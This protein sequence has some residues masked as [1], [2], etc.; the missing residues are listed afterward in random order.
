MLT[1]TKNPNG[2]GKMMR[3]VKCL[4]VVVV[5][6]P[7]L[8]LAASG[9]G[10]MDALGVGTP[11]MAASA[12]NPGSQFITVPL[13]LTNSQGLA[14]ADIP[15]RF[16]DPG[17]GVELREVK[18]NSRIDYFDVK[19][20]NIDNTNKTVVIGLIPMAFNPSKRE[21]QPSSGPVADLVFEVT[22]P[23]LESFTIQATTMERPHHRMVWVF[24]DWSQ[25]RPQVTS[26][27][28]AFEPVVV[29]VA[30]ARAS[31]PTTYAL[32]QNYPNPFNPSTEIAFALPSAGRVTLTVYNVLGQAVKT[33]VDGDLEAGSHQVTWDGTSNGGSVAASG[34]YFY[35]IQAS[36][37]VA[38]KKMTLLK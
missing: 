11:S 19:L 15:L 36:N 13:Y 18:F 3:L 7:A 28:P 2:G 16:A 34:I 31:L 14:A 6:V 5:L 23:N 21:L 22:D 32:N 4:A 10:K 30:A 25:T 29:P 26:T 17:A 20:A 24:N 37:F 8:A 35:R 38:T 27:T 9:P 12:G 1:K 33:L